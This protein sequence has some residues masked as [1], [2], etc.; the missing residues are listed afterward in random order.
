MEC[1]TGGYPVP[2]EVSTG[3]IAKFTSGTLVFDKLILKVSNFTA[4]I[5]GEGIKE[6][7]NE[8]MFFTL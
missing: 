3:S 4:I 1:L 7:V 6:D 5:R 2:L 8:V